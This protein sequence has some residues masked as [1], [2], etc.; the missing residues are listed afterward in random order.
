MFSKLDAEIVSPKTPPPGWVGVTGNKIN[1]FSR[2]FMKFLGLFFIFDPLKSPLRP[3][4]GGVGR[5]FLDSNDSRIY[6]HM[7][8]KFGCDPPV[9]SKKG[10]T[11][12]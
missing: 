2:Q 7:L 10:G 11:D 6:P 1:R 12:T 8:A 9:V 4:C 3:P 5:F